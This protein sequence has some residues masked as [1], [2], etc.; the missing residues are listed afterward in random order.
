MLG[1]LKNEYKLSKGESK[2]KA[3]AKVESKNVSI[4][5][6]VD[7]MSMACLVLRSSDEPPEI[8]LP[9]RLRSAGNLSGSLPSKMKIEA[10]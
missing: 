2:Q 10:A 8:D 5:W 3:K 6:Q 9:Y 4:S 7:E 1:R